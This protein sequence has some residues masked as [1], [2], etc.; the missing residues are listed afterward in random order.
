MINK[1]FLWQG[2]PS[3]HPYPDATLFSSSLSYSARISSSSLWSSCSG[4]A[5]PAPSDRISLLSWRRRF[6]SSSSDLWKEHT[7]SLF[8]TQG[9]S[10]CITLC[11][12]QFR[13]KLRPFPVVQ[14]RD[15]CVYP[16]QDKQTHHDC[17]KQFSAMQC[18]WQQQQ[19]TCPYK[20]LLCK[21]PSKH[22]T[23]EVI[24]SL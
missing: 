10:T 24:I 20:S 3:A 7:I 17:L 1:K 16:Q 14:R 21:G 18:R 8:L 15:C 2:T 11:H 12:Q 9:S 4:T 5:A 19:K 6:V 23:P 22:L 13:G